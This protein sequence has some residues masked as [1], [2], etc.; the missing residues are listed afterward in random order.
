[1]TNRPLRS[2]LQRGSEVCAVLFLSCGTVRQNR[3]YRGSRSKEY[4]VVEFYPYFLSPVLQV[5]IETFY[6]TILNY[7]F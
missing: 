3:L 5:C 1:M 2:S 6:K 4:V 7:L